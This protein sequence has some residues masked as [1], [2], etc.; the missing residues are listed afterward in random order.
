M[1]VIQLKLISSQ[2]PS[3]IEFII[4]LIPSKVLITFKI[5]SKAV[6]FQTCGH[7]S[8]KWHAHNSEK[9]D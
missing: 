3:L 7:V 9:K 1:F 4:L 8:I 2:T 5:N 6:I